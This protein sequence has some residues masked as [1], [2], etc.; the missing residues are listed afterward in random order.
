MTNNFMM[1]I[2]D[3]NAMGKTYYEY[4]WSQWSFNM[5]VMIKPSGWSTWRV[6]R[7]G[8][9]QSGGQQLSAE[10][11]RLVF[12]FSSSSNI[13]AWAGR[14][15]VCFAFFVFKNFWRAAAERRVLDVSWSLIYFLF[16]GWNQ[17]SRWRWLLN[18]GLQTTRSNDY[19]DA[20]DDDGGD[21]N[22]DDEDDDDMHLGVWSTH[23]EAF[24]R[25]LGRE[26]LG[27][28]S[29]VVLHHHQHHHQHRHQQ[30]H[31]HHHHH[32]YDQFTTVR[33]ER[34]AEMFG[35]ENTSKLIPSATQVRHYDAVSDLVVKPFPKR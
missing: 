17:L 27:G 33:Q 3:H 22:D 10:T 20:D 34:F 15:K 26:P 14:P 4:W 1:I 32:Y 30:R 6:T 28:A 5:R 7:D 31:Q 24:G 13:D 19:P 11:W 2:Y 12:F 8:G 16:L 25:H 35:S 29:Q 21:S 9:T 23:W 18:M